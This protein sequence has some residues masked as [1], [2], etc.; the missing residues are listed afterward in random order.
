MKVLMTTD[1]VGGVWHYALCLCRELLARGHEIVL[2][3]MGSGLTETQRSAVAANPGLRVAESGYRL[4]WMQDAAADVVASGD[5]LL[6][7]ARRH[8]ADLVHVNSYAHAAFPFGRQVLA[9]AHSDVVS[10]H[11]WVRRQTPSDE[12]NAYRFGAERGLDRASA[13]VAPTQAVRDDLVQ[14]FGIPAERCRIIENGIPLDLYGPGHKE[15]L[16]LCAGRVWD[17]AKNIAQLARIA[18]RI[19]WPIQMAGEC[20]SPDGGTFTPDGLS[21]L[22]YLDRPVMAARLASAAIFAAPARYEPFGLAIAEAAASG[23][24]LVLSDLPSLREVWGDAALYVP[25]D[26]DEAWVAVLNWLIAS[27]AR[28]RHLGAAAR[29]RARRYSAARMADRYLALYAELCQQT[30]LAHV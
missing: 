10:W 27:P 25:V 23:C 28:R 15:H 20:Q 21:L 4:E 11:R 6:A 9:V 8:G 14:A 16:V 30:E 13:I 17:E 12:W 19:S 22:G 5:W 29:E 24:A 26:H 2:A 7:L 3:T 18:G 1:T